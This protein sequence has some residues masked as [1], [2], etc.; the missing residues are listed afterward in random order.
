MEQP[1]IISPELFRWAITG[2]AVAVVSLAVF[3]KVI[4]KTIL[5]QSKENSEKVWTDAKELHT[6][7]NEIIKDINER[8][9]KNTGT[10]EEM[11]TDV[12][13]VKYSI[14]TL[15]RIIRC[16]ENEEDHSTH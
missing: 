12:K 1:D 7:T 2:M 15:N 9:I 16:K 6:A 11:K 4:F 8:D 5:D 3:I 10:L 13:E 14:L